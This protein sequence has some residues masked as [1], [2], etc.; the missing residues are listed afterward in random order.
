MLALCWG[1]RVIG[2][3]G[4]TLIHSSEWQEAHL[5]GEGAVP[6]KPT[7]SKSGSQCNGARRPGPLQLSEFPG[8]Q[9]SQRV[10]SNVNLYISAPV[11]YVPF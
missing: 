11:H 7:L 5:T 4:H 8:T 2:L 1:W 6:G 9:H 3:L 10:L